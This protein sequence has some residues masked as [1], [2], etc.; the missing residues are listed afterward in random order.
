MGPFTL[1]ENGRPGLRF[2]EAGQG[3]FFQ[4]SSTTV[5]W[6]ASGK[7]IANK[8]VDIDMEGK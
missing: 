5:V 3:A 7:V 1:G 2:L 4:K 8:A 6:I